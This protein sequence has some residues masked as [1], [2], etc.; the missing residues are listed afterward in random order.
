MQ[1]HRKD[2]SRTDRVNEQVLRELAEVIRT[3]MRDPRVQWV[4][5]TSVEVTRDYSYAKVFFTVMESDK[6]EKSQIALTQAAGFL[7]SAL[8]KRISLFN[9]PQLQF[10]YDE[11]VERGASMMEL[12]NKLSL[13]DKPAD[14]E[15]D[16]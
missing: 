12:L 2:F 5:L 6:K 16:S 15:S 8:A 7:R 4:T 10:I 1:H 13:E 14:E 9:A 3:E 11:S